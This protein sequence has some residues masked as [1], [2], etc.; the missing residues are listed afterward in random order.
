MPDSTP[1]QQ[2]PSPG[3]SGKPLLRS[4]RLD[5][6]IHTMP[7]K[8][9]GNQPSRPGG[10]NRW[11]LVAV[12]VLVLLLIAGGSLLAVRLLQQRQT[13][14]NTNQAVVEN[15]N[16][17]TN[18]NTANVN[19]AANANGNANAN[20]NVNADVA[21]V[22]KGSY[23]NPE[24]NS[25]VSTLTLTLPAGA[26]ADAAKLGVTALS[27]QIGAY[28][29]STEYHTIGAVYLLTPAKTALL[30]KATVAITYTDQ[31]LLD[32]DLPVK[33]DTL[34]VASWNGSEWVPMTSTVEKSANTV[35]AS[36]EEFPSDGIAVV[37]PQT[38]STNANTNAVANANANTNSAAVVPSQDSDSDGLTNQEEML[39]GTNANNMDTDADSYRDGQEVLALYNPNGKNRLA[40]SSLVKTYENTTYHYALL[41]PASW[42]VGT[43]SADKS[44]LFTSITG[45]FVQVSVQTNTAKQ[46]A[47]EWYLSLNPSVP[48]TSL[49][50]V[51]VGTLSGIIGPDSLNIYLADTAY[52]YQITYNIGIKSEANFLTTFTMMYSSFAVTGSTGTNKNSNTN[53]ASANKNT[54]TG[55]TNTNAAKNTNTA[56]NANTSAAENANAAP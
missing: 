51:T 8:F 56:S 2:P 31:E 43:L 47:R 40:E 20:A 7:G 1:S 27:A 33:E 52:I 14:P 45:E 17:V 15:R 11:F 19:S 54:N 49:R 21:T 35:T 13:G 38:V 30:K 4:D 42:T 41:Y 23:T 39:Y 28:A 50:D 34:A 12:V 46:S 36:I 44:V 25:V 5:A 22:L 9:L 6:T 24:T 29:T 55:S 32:L 53:S 16:A 10:S 48:Q 37:A 18:T 3:R 26:I